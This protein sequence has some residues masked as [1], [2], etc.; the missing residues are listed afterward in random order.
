MP[1]NDNVIDSLAIE[2]VGQAQGALEDL[3]SLITNLEGIKGKL[4]ELGSAK[5]R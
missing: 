2:V 1:G 5:S 4:A 3:Q